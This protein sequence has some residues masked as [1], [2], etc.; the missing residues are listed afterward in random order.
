MGVSIY[1]WLSCTYLGLFKNILFLERCLNFI[2][3]L[4]FLTTSPPLVCH[5][6]CLWIPYSFPCPS[7]PFPKLAILIFPNSSNGCSLPLRKCFF[8]VLEDFFLYLF[9]SIFFPLLFLIN[10]IIS[11]CT[12]W[13]QPLGSEFVSLI[14][15]EALHC[16][17]YIVPICDPLHYDSLYCL[18]FW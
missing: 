6:T 14:S 18:S 16:Y 9:I 15:W 11:P 10:A 2:R 17:Q 5:I 12:S 1:L 7:K 8:R 3:H 4:S 13:A